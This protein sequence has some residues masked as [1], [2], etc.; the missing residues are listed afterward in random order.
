MKKVSSS[1]INAPRLSKSASLT[2]WTRQHLESNKQHK[3]GK[4]EYS[5]EKFGLSE[6]RVKSTM[7][8]YEEEF[9]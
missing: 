2:P 9:L 3:H 1:V 5:V 8:R 4:A 6:A 7:S